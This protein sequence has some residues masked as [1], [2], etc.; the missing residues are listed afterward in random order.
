MLDEKQIEIFDRLVKERVLEFANIKD[1]I[2]PNN[3]VYILKHGENESKG[4]GN[5]LM[6]LKLFEDL[7]DGDINPK[8]LLKNQERFKSCL[9]EI[10][11]GVNKSVNQKDTIKNIT[12][13]FDLQ[14][15][16]IDFFR[17]YSF[18]QEQDFVFL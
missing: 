17:D 13:L 14:Q 4:F 2:D 16:F 10:K 11:I 18:Q 6:P 8:E 7:R 1:K 5:C 15:K 9:I 3:L 12:I